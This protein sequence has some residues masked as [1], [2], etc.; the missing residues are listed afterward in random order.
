MSVKIRLATHED[1]LLGWM[2]HGLKQYG[3][4]HSVPRSHSTIVDLVYEE[5]MANNSLS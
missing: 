3:C 4:H 5:A 1:R 2:V